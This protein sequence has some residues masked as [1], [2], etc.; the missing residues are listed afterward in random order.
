MSELNLKIEKAKVSDEVF[1]ELVKAHEFFILRTCGD[2]CNRYITKS[3]DEWSVALSGFSKA[4]TAFSQERGD[5]IAFAKV[6]IKNSLI[7]YMRK[8]KSNEILVSPQTFESELNESS[9]HI[10]FEVER[11]IKTSSTNNYKN[12]ELKDEIESATSVFSVYGFSFFD[13]AS[14][15]PKSKKTKN[16]CKAA[17][18]T[19]IEND[20]L[21]KKMR[22]NRILPLKEIEKISEVPR[23]IL[24]RHRKYIIA[25]VELISG[26]YPHHAQYLHCITER[27]EHR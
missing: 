13:L 9:S 27:G 6:I 20:E 26:D 1:E 11:T 12:I 25:A 8:N 14:C 5:F 22:S 4:V 19:I 21:I 16:S 3:D 2:V 10:D 18:M 15:S 7:D 24:E 23:K 17:V